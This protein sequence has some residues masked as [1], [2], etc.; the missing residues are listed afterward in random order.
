MKQ[1]LNVSWPKLNPGAG[2]RALF[3]QL[4]DKG[5]SRVPTEPPKSLVVVA[6]PSR[7]LS[8]PSAFL[9]WL[10]WQLAGSGRD[11]R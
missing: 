6:G 4:Q 7:K 5:P 3:R 10:F 1:T 9:L 8:R 11:H 2:G